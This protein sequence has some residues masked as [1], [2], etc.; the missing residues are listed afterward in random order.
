VIARLLADRAAAPQLYA[1]GGYEP[2]AAQ[3]E[4]SRNVVAFRRSRAGDD[5]IVVVPRLF[6]GVAGG[7]SLPLGAEF[8][9]DTALRAPAGRR[10]EILTGSELRCGEGGLPLRELFSALPIAVLRTI[11]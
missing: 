11:E 8:W 5:L 1:E 7:G 9:G 4:R 6:A 2:L 10:R 3:G